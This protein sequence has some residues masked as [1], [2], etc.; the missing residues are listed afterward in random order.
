[1]TATRLLPLLAAVCSRAD[2]PGS[3]WLELSTKI[4]PAAPG[5]VAERWCVHAPCASLW[6]ARWTAPGLYTLT[7][8]EAP[9]PRRRWSISGPPRWLDAIRGGWDHIDGHLQRVV[10]QRRLPGC[11]LPASSRTRVDLWRLV[12]DGDAAP[13]IIAPSME[14][15]SSWKRVA[16]G[17]MQQF[18]QSLAV[19]T[20]V[21][22][23]HR[24]R[25]G[26]SEINAGRLQVPASSPDAGDPGRPGAWKP[27]GAK[28]VTAGTGA[29][30]PNGSAMRPRQYR[31]EL[32]QE[33]PRPA[34]SA[35]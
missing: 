9:R 25:D 15:R 20:P 30:Q 5:S 13:R 7:T 4:K 27:G 22:A 33:F 34:P 14:T 19:T 23:D 18:G 26:R 29:D 12:R 1:M 11:R 24:Q 6:S 2:L 28:D 16:H 10:V 21:R 32:Q 17:K 31:L 35:G 3:L 8:S